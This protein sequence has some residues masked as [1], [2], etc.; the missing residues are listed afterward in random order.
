MANKIYGKFPN[1]DDQP[2]LKDDGHGNLK[3]YWK[4]YFDLSGK[5]KKHACSSRVRW[6]DSDKYRRPVFKANMQCLDG[7]S[8]K[9]YWT[10]QDASQGDR[11][12]CEAIQQ[13]TQAEPP[14]RKRKVVVG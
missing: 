7:T 3:C 11:E 14:A 13:T 6:L 1:P 5:E 10:R 12:V 4:M 2:I 9:V 8:A